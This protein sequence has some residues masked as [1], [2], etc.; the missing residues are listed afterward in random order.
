MYTSCGYYSKTILPSVL[1]FKH[2]GAWNKCPL[3]ERKNRAYRMP[4]IY[5]ARILIN[6]GH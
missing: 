5:T 4:E 3:L 6:M 1:A 2:G